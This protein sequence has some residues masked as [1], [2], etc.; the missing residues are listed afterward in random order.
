MGH[1]PSVPE[2]PNWRETHSNCVSLCMSEILTEKWTLLYKKLYVFRRPYL[3]EP[4]DHILKVVH[5]QKQSAH[6]AVAVD[7]TA[8]VVPC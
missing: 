2:R 6:W 4:S 1:K 3:D 7:V 8:Q 5:S